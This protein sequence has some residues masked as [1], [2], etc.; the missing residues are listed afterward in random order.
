MLKLLIVD[1]EYLSIESIKL[2]IDKYIEDIEIVG[3]AKSGRE[4]IEKAVQLK[5]DVIF[6]DI[7]MPGINGID[8]IKQIKS[9]NNNTK[10]VMITAYEYF[11]YAKEA[12]NLGVHDYILKPLTKNKIIKTLSE[13]NDVIKKE[14]EVIK[15]EMIMKEKVN[16][17]IPIME[18][19]FIYSNILDEGKIANVEFYEDI[20][21]MK[22]SQGYILMAY[23]NEFNNLDNTRKQNFYE[24]FTLSLKNITDCV[25]SLPINDRI[26]AYI[27]VDEFIDDNY[28]KDMSILIANKVYQKIRMNLDYK[29]GIG[30]NYSIDSILK[31]YNEAYIAISIPNDRVVTHYEDISIDIN[32][33]DL[34]SDNKIEV[35]LQK[36]LMGD[37]NETLNAV[38]DIFYRLSLS[39]IKDINKIKAKILEVLMEIRKTTNPDMGKTTTFDQIY[40]TDVIEADNINNLK[41]TVKNYIKSILTDVENLRSSKLNGII[42]EAL[43]YISKNY[44]KDISLDDVA[45][46]L[47]MSYH[48]FSKFFKD[49]IGKNFVDY[50]TELR[51]EKS[52]ELL[53][54]NNISIKEICYEIGYHDP[55]YFSK[56]FR[57]VTGM[58]PTDY[59]TSII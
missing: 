36:I 25:V 43:D 56:I 23:I 29:I 3:T 1:D 51:I 49:T 12:I 15:Q 9:I 53:K 50:L 52:K 42:S 8:A 40:I 26:I 18:N 24:T 5:P 57:K 30:R 20:L 16:K 46:E 2:I 38:D 59:R 47:N 55:N 6:M 13:L 21:G 48:Y 4:A 31:S 54:N 7:K 45:R 39:S 34:Y 27:T 37:L 14:R 33:L 10:F 19:Q 11:D 41:T 28:I 17:T 35:L 58:T 32:K 22:L 44:N